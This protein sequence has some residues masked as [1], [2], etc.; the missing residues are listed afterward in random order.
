MAGQD[1]VW[2]RESI[3]KFSRVACKVAA[4]SSILSIAKE[5]SSHRPSSC[6][7]G[8]DADGI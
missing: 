6:K 5:A 7:G 8:V 3:H 4:G 1:G 2:C